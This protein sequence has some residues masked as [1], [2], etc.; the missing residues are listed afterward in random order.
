MASEA[1]LRGSIGIFRLGRALGIAAW[2][3]AAGPTASAQPAGKPSMVSIAGTGRPTYVLLSG[4]LGGTGGF[5]R[6][7]AELLSHGCRVVAIDAYALSLDSTDVAFAALAR[8]VNA[9]LHRLGADSVLVVGHAHGGGVALRLAALAPERVSA[10]YLLDVGALPESRTKVFSSALRLVPLLTRLPG[11][12]GFVRSRLM[13][14]IRRNAG[15][16]EW[17]DTVTQRTYT[18]PVLDRIGEVV[19]MA[20]RLA[21]AREPEP[22]DRVVA[23]VRAPV[24]L[25]LGEVPHPSGPDSAE[26]TALES[27]GERVRIERLAGVGHFPHEEAPAE[28]ARILL[29]RDGATRPRSRMP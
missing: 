16:Q 22:L 11:G 25:I 9:E 6:L 1:A 27:L 17:L 4:L 18:E 29:D 13:R 5:R 26:L 14:G 23:R 2:A 19:A 3:L 28:V 21:T 15:R 24:T 20:R 10:L 8:R 7:Q 12:R